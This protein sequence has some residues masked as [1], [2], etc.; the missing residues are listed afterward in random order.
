MA[1]QSGL[2]DALWISGYDVSGDI[3]QL[4]EIQG[5]A[6]PI[7][8]TGINKAAMERILGVRD[9][10]ID[11]TTFFNPTNGPGEIASVH[12][13]LSLLPTADQIVTYGRGTT[14]GAAAACLT[15]KQL[16]YDMKRGTEGEV[17]FDESSVANA[18]GLEWGNQLTAG[19]RTDTAATNGA[20]VDFGLGSSGTGPSEFG[21]QFY[22]HV[23]AFTGT[24]V[25]VK[26]QESADNG[27]GDA[28]ADVVGGTFAAATG[29]T[30]QRLE[31]ARGQ[32]VERYLRAI[33][34]GTFSE[35]VFAVV[36]NRN[37]APT[38]F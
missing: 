12:E 37:D 22:L 31:T 16:N 35:A 11:A 24:S 23:F 26:I 19:Q 36:A 33:T 21:A 1:K 4:N 18:F 29:I 34:I 38:F 3:Q 6:S 14:L 27:V 25:T 10:K 13:R 32:T 2:G 15:S 9:G 17:T 5:G 28:W 30:T 7:D 8:V 20:G